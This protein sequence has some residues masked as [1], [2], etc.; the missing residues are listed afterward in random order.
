[1]LHLLMES[2]KNLN[3]GVFPDEERRQ[4][5]VVAKRSALPIAKMENRLNFNI[6]RP[7]MSA[8]SSSA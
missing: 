4:F 1:M 5:R 2:I 6:K 3:G 8:S 7:D